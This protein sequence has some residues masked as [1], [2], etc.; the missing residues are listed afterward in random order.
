MTAALPSLLISIPPGVIDLGWGHP[1]PRLHPA[2]ELAEA[3]RH[4]LRRQSP[5]PLQYG[6]TQG[7]GQLLESLAAY[8]SGQDAY[9]PGAVRPE[10]LFLTAGASQGIDLAATILARAGDTV[11]V[12]EP[13]YYLIGQIFLDHGLQICGVPTDAHGLDTGALAAM[14]AG[15]N[16]PRLLYTIPAYQNP[17]GSVLPLERRRHLI[18]LARRY[19]FTI[20]ADEVYQLLHYGPPPP[21]PLA[22]LDAATADNDTDASAKADASADAKAGAPAAGRAISLGSFSKILAPGLRL[23]WLHAAPGVIRQFADSG[24]AAS[25]GGLNHFAATLAHSMLELDLLPANIARLRQ[26]YGERHDAVAELLQGELAGAFDFAPPGGG[27]FF[28]LT[29]RHDAGDAAPAVDTAALLP[30]AQAAGVS[31]RPGPAF[32]AAGGFRNALRIAISL[33]E[34]GD[35]I[36]ALRR[37]TAVIRAGA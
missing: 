12:E 36:K 14:L 22:M 6:A 16:I 34:T 19:G 33:Y 24:L 4:A 23:G 29:C 2:G 3:A 15:G 13:T 35:L 5:V 10:S 17:G 20:L 9:G 31:Y 32:S 27:Y 8:L 26:I 30:A 18:D 1:S 7:Y 21:P 37:L 11:F 25:G 28:W